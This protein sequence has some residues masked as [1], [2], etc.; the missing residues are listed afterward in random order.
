MKKITKKNLTKEQR[1]KLKKAL[2][3]IDHVIKDKDIGR[4]ICFCF[5]DAIR[6]SGDEFSCSH[7]IFNAFLAT[8]KEVVINIYSALWWPYKEVKPRLNHMNRIKNEI[9]KYL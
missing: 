2:I 6:A 8:Q 5:P 9:L 3:A 4:G 1:E 7:P